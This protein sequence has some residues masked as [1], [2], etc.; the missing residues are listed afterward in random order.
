MLYVNKPEYYGG[1]A[2][3]E[4]EGKEERVVCKIEPV[5]VTAFG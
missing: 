2:P 5:K 3:T 4:L 1:V